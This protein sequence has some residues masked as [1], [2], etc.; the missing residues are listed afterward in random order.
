MRCIKLLNLLWIIV[1][2]SVWSGVKELNQIQEEAIQ[3]ID[4]T[5]MVKD[6]DQHLIDII[7]NLTHKDTK[8]GIGCLIEYYR[9][10][11]RNC[12]KKTIETVNAFLKN[13]SVHLLDNYL[14]L[15]C[16][17]YDINTL[18]FHLDKDA[19][20]RYNDQFIFAINFLKDKI[21]HTK[22][23]YKKQHAI[24]LKSLIQQYNDIL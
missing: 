10:A 15:F 23:H 21:L 2:I 6:Y 5:A 16:S 7:A 17:D 11:N 9:L 19:V 13:V 18:T 3:K 8:E 4:I 22:F 24:A 14:L 20:Q 12:C 1:P